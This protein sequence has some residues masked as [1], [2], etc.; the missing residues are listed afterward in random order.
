MKQ[1]LV[2]VIVPTKNSQ[3]TIDSCLSSIKKQSYKNIELIVVDNNSSDK[4][5]QISRKYTDL[6]LNKGPERS[7]QRNWGARKSK[8]E[9]LFFIDSDMVL[10]KNVVREAVSLISSK[11]IKLVVIPEE[12]FGIGFWSKC[13]SLERSFYLGVKWMEAARFFDRD[14]FIKF[15]GYDEKNTGTEDYDLPQRIKSELGEAT[16]GR[17][18]ELIYHNEGNLKLFGTLK[19]KFYYA[20]KLK[21]YSIK[22][23]NQKNYE[24]Q[25]NL[26]K[27]YQLFFSKPKIIR[28]QPLVFI[29]MI[30]MK[31]LEFVFGG[32]GVI[33]SKFI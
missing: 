27:R 8:G 5:I 10:S 24:N 29:G 21:E 6:I 4:T 15:N 30:I 25:S 9:F 23:E 12:S 1:S 31:T 19:K 20:Q 18:K 3:N 26:F 13:K 11:D 33:Y 2:S 14:V 22:S 17:I 7:S 32:L 28:E 16:E